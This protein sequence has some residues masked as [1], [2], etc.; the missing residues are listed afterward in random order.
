MRISDGSSDVFSYDLR[1][2]AT[3]DAF[4]FGFRRQI[5]L[6]LAALETIDQCLA[7]RRAAR[8]HVLADRLGAFAARDRADD[9]EAPLG[10]AI[11]ALVFERPA[12]QPLHNALGGR[13]V[14][15]AAHVSELFF[16]RSEE[17][18]SEL[19]SLMRTSYAVFCLKKK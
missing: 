1:E 4:D 8:D 2:Q 7:R 11:A 15:R 16:L 18:T 13:R 12:Q 5:A 6:C 17:H 3:C 14:E 19:Q 10:L 9:A